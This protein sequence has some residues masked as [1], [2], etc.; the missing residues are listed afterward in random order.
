MKGYKDPLNRPHIILNM[1]QS[2][3][4]YISK[5][6][7]ERAYI[8]SEEDNIRVQTLRNKSDGILVGYR[9]VIKDNPSLIAPQNENSRRLIIDPHCS[10]T[11]NYRVMDGKRRTVILNSEKNKK[12]DDNIEYVYC[13]KPFSLEKSLEIIYEMGISSMLVEGGKVT[14]ES[15]L[16]RGLVDEMY[17][18]I[19]DLFLEEGGILSP[20]TNREIRNVILDVRIMKG[21]LLLKI[22]PSKFKRETK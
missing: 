10:L 17:M 3:N 22:D 7:G 13:G 21:G 1:A 18:F 9:T 15:F 20:T 12:I 2:I 19:G 5:I 8:S 14:A 4:G 6:S 16:N 11:Q